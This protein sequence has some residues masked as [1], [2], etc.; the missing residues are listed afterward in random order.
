[1]GSAPYAPFDRNNGCAIG[2]IGNSGCLVPT[3]PCHNA[4][5]PL[6]AEGVQELEGSSVYG[7]L[8]PDR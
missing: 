4:W 1:M 6:D 3:N 2:H 8:R 7:L 5:L